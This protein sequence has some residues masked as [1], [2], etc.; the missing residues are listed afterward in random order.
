MARERTTIWFGPGWV[1]GADETERGVFG[2]V[3]Q[4]AVFDGG[5]VWAPLCAVQGGRE[6][7]EMLTALSGQCK[8]VSR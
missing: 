5:I 1:Y 2:L 4:A 8:Q 6:D 7:V 3:S